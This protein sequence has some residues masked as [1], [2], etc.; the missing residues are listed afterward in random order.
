MTKTV[1][2][3]ISDAK[4]LIEDP[5]HWVQYTMAHDSQGNTVDPED[6][7]AVSFCSVGALYNTISPREK[8]FYRAIHYLNDASRELTGIL[9]VSA[10]DTCSHR[11]IMR[12]F[13]NAI[14]N[15]KENNE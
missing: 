8:E 15:A 13:D 2:E 7:E 10:N 5:E 4:K 6:K 9:V 14:K 1:T 12:I 11:S 3:I